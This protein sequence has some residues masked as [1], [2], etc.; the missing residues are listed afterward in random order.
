M[1]R[2]HLRERGCPPWVGGA[3]LNFEPRAR[4]C[5][6]GRA[7]T[8]LVLQDVGLGAPRAA[9]CSSYCSRAPGGRRPCPSGLGLGWLT[10]APS[11][12]YCTG[13]GDPHYVTFD[14]L[15]YS[16]QGNCTYVLV[17]EIVPS[18]HGF[19]VYIDNYHCDASDRVS[20][21]RTLIVRYEAREVLIK[22]MRMLPINVQ[23]RWRGQ[24]HPHGVR[25]VPGPSLRRA[26][27]PSQAL[28]DRDPPRALVAV[29]CGRSP[30]AGARAHTR[31]ELLD[32]VAQ[33]ASPSAQG[34]S[35]DRVLTISSPA[36]TG[37]AQGSGREVERDQGRGSGTGGGGQGTGR[38]PHT[39][40]TGLRTGG[41][42]VTPGALSRCSSPQLAPTR[43]CE[44]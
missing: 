32:P 4:L 40:R 34:G 6:A 18:G 43:P 12:G 14:G 30:R 1:P 42:G 16:Y 10:G 28:R 41:A 13:W 2:S 21:P 11:T 37:L 22:M 17:E 23:V 19:G 20:C 7:R 25:G 38:G 8:P 24:G 5:P 44:G 15:Y 27:L 35:R 36:G 26:G 3:E 39:G 33:G 9:E 29:C 31:M